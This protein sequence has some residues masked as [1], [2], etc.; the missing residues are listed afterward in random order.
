MAKDIMVVK[1]N[2]NLEKFDPNRVKKAAIAS[3]ERVMVDLTDEALDEIDAEEKKEIENAIDEYLASLNKDWENQ[4]NIVVRIS[5]I[6]TRVLGIPTVI[7]ITGTKINGVEENY[8]ADKDSIVKRGE[9]TN[10]K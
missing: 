5:Q 8:T 1:R 7:D 6:E 4:D 2:G 3:A 9:L 10:G